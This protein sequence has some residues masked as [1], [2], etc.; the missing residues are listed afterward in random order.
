MKKFLLLLAFSAG[1]FISAQEEIK[2]DSIVTD[3]VKHWSVLGKQSLMINQAAFSNWVGGGANN[4][5]WLLGIDYNIT[6]EKDKDLWENLILLNYGQNDTK[7]LGVRK[8]QDVINVSTNYGRKISK[9]WYL[10]VGAGLQSQFTVGY[11]DGNNPE[12]KKIS[13]FMAPGYLNLGMGITFRPNDNVNV[14]LRPSNARWTLVLDSDLQTAG[15]YGLKA[16]SDTS[17]L[18]YGF[19]GTALYKFK[20]MENINITN[21]ASVFSNYLDHPERL[22]LAYGMILNLKVN[23]FISSN[24]T[25]DLMY[26][27]NQI[28]KTQ[29]KQT[30]G[31]GFSYILN[32]GVKRSDRKDSQWWIKK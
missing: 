19:L 6:Y 16:D 12:A 8:T 20:L 5:G 29:L 26:D 10:S 11:E 25:V 28:E 13:N 30:L 7:G 15:T 4:V 27:H 23:K 1:V 14:T 18:Q 24:I 2:K 22:V 31:V 17:L 21:T 32:N 9:S 3:T